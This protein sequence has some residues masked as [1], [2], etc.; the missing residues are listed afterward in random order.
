MAATI[1]ENYLSRSFTLGA[2]AVRELI[3]DI[4]A[5][6][7][8]SSAQSILASTAPATWQG[9]YLDSLNADPVGGDLWKGYARYTTRQLDN[10]YTFDTTGGT[11]K[12][13]Q[14]LGTINKYAPVGLEAPDF[15]GA[16]GVSEDKVEGV[17]I[18]TP[19]YQFTETHYFTDT[20]VDAAFKFTIFGL[21]GKMNNADFK[22]FAPG[23]VL[24]LGATGGRRGDDNW[25]ITYR[26]ACSPNVTGIGIGGVIPEDAY[27]DATDNTITGIDKLGWD[28][29]WVRYDDYEDSIAFALVKQP[30]AVYIERVYEPADFSLLGIGTT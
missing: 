18:T 8:D 26:F 11:T 25:S 15:Q 6:T 27:Y 28:Y 29:M 9:L 5:A 20:D 12:I 21:T 22:G 30:T 1:S 17:D 16:I 24:F 4:H 14:S 10:E 19:V 7:D 3:Y 13:T 2:Q 23:E